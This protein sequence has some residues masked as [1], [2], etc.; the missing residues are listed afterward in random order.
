M[1][2]FKYDGPGMGKGGTGVLSVD[3]KEVAKKT[4]PHTIPALVTID[5]SFDV[6]VDTRTGVDDK[7]YQPPF[8]FTGKLDKLTIKLGPN[9]MPAEDEK[10]K[11]DAMARVNN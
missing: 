7:D 10:A 6:G 5:E 1:F 3:G 8:R 4:I 9:Q 11:A 2:D